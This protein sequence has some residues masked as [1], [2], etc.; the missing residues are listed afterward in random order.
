MKVSDDMPAHTKY[1]GFPL[2]HAIEVD[3]YYVKDCIDHGD[4]LVVDRVLP[5]VEQRI[6]EKE[7]PFKDAPDWL[8]GGE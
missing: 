1:S 2:A 4:I 3:P 8:T 6:E 5:L 7:A